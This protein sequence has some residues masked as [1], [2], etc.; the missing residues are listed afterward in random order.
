MCHRTGH[1]RHNISTPATQIHWKREKRKTQWKKENKEK[2]KETRRRRNNKGNEYLFNTPEHIAN[3]KGR[4]KR[5]RLNTP[6]VRT[7][8]YSTRS[9]PPGDATGKTN[10]NKPKQKAT[11][12]STPPRTYSLPTKTNKTYFVRLKRNKRNQNK[13]KSHSKQ[14]RQI[15]RYEQHGHVL[16]VPTTTRRRSNCWKAS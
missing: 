3:S 7:E 16:R 9:R 5:G 11:T 1:D 12:K 2:R 15:L 10:G 13:T 4:P 6:S 14:P 8:G